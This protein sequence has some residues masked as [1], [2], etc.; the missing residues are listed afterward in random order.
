MSLN[1][2]N[3]FGLGAVAIAAVLN[4]C[5]S[6][7]LSKVTLI[8]PFVNHQELLNYL[9]R[10]S[11]QVKSLDKLIVEKTVF[12]TNFNK[13][14]YDSL[15]STINALQYLN[16]QGYIEFIDNEVSLIKP[17][18]YSKEMGA[19]T[20]KIFLASKNIS[21]IFNELVEKLYLNLR[22]EL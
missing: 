5:N 14:Y 1:L 7:P 3:N 4:E 20:S 9:S 8:F 21:L 22:I 17:M 2:Y 11:T 12:F 15:S 18:V 10:K 16:D 19:R 6:L 13:R